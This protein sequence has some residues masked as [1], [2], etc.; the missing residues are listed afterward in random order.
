VPGSVPVPLLLRLP[1]AILVIAWAARTDRA[2]LLPVG[3]LLAMPVIWW[4]SLAI[5]TATVALRRDRIEAHVDRLLGLLE[6]RRGRRRAAESV[7]TS[8]A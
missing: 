2:W 7:G 5:L 8:P 3:V 4:G 1:V 6:E